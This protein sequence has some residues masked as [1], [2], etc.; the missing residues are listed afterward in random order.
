MH[1]EVTIMIDEQFR[2]PT[3]SQPGTTEEELAASTPVEEP[4]AGGEQTSGDQAGAGEA[5]AGEDAQSAK[6]RQEAADD[7]RDSLSNLSSALDRFGKAAEAR[8]RQEWEQG[9]PEIN[10]AVEEMKRGLDGLIRKTGGVFDNVSQR[11]N[12]EES[13]STQAGQG[14]PDHEHRDTAP[15]LPDAAAQTPGHGDISGNQHSSPVDFP[16]PAP[17]EPASSAPDEA[18]GPPQEAD[19]HS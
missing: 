3:E 14:T 12:K 2:Q 19:S 5:T 13:G 4:A 1:V 9:R 8:V 6:A 7:F 10:R 16:P 18:P 11:L 17:S 15:D